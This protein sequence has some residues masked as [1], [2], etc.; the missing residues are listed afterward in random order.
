MKT[1]VEEIHN[2]FDT[3]ADRMLAEANEILAVGFEVQKEARLASLGFARSKQATAVDKA[4]EAAKLIQHYKHSY[5]AHKFITEDA[6]RDICKRY[7]LL[8]G[9]VDKFVGDVPEKNLAEIESFVVKEED[10]KKPF[11]W[12]SGLSW[13]NSPSTFGWLDEIQSTG[14]MFR[15]GVDPVSIDT[16][17]TGIVTARARQTGKTSDMLQAYG[18]ALHAQSEKKAKEAIKPKFE[19]CAPEK[20]FN[21]QN[22]K[23]KG[24]KLV[25]EDPI[26]LCPV[27]GGYLVV[28]KWGLEASDPSVLDE[29][30]N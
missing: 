13:F 29:R 6:V 12:M 22:M 8:L 20:D 7:K 2:E 24:H 14:R 21:T 28:S 18:M 25:P 11:E 26:V 27:K 23:K 16:E 4:S 10:Y 9:G 15:A 30:M 1:I 17:T 19:I 3:A 5:P